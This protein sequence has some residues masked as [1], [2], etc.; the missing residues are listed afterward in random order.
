MKILRQP[1]ATYDWKPV[2]IAIVTGLSNPESCCLSEDQRSLLNAVSDGQN[3]AILWNFPFIPDSVP[4][5]DVRLLQASVANGLQFLRCGTSRY[6]Q[7]ATPHWKALAEATGCLLIVTGSCGIQLLSCW[8]GVQKQAHAGRIRA[9]ALGPVGSGQP[10]FPVTV[11]QGSHD[12]ISRIW[13]RNP[14]HVV[15]GVGHLD[16]WKNTQSREI[17]LRWLRDS[18]SELSARPVFCPNIS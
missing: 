15:N 16:Y 1:P 18:I 3:S 12:W 7:L 8:S 11:V 4:R 6:Q 9:L 10:E 17:V 14:D 5:T 13:F 2:R